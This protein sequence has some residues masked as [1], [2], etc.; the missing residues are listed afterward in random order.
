[1]PL[2]A[3]P[4][5][6]VDAISP[7]INRAKNQLFA[8]FRPGFW[9]RMAVLAFFTGELSGGGI[10]F[11]SGGFD[12][13]KQ[14][15]QDGTN[16]FVSIPFDWNAVMQALPWLLAL[17]LLV[18]IFLLVFLYIHSVLRFVLFDSVVTGQCSLQ[19][20]W[21]RRRGN[22]A[23]YFAW[24]MIFQFFAFLALVILVGLPVLFAWQ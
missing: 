4:L 13:P 8:P 6:A 24:L 23:Q 7:A 18:T 3:Q 20:G 14:P 1:M 19:Q 11:P 5:S 16:N 21:R 17:A 10:N 12:W 22:G 15:D 2:P 9:W